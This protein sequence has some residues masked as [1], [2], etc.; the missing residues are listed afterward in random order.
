MQS[1]PYMLIVD[2]HPLVARGVGE[3]LRALP[4]SIE[5]RFALNESE[6][7]RTMAEH[8]EPRLLLVD[9]WL[10]DGTALDFVAH[11]R[12]C[13]PGVCVAVMSGDDDPAVL[14]RSR[15]AGAHGFIP[16]H[17]S[18]DTFGQAVRALLE[19]RVW[20]SSPKPSTQAPSH[21]VLPVTPAE[22]G[23]SARQGEI[24]ALVL[25]GLP[26]K[27]IAQQLELSE[28]T[29]KE[30]VSAVLLRLGV[31]TRVDAIML[32]QGRRLALPPGAEVS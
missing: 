24:L 17:E 7:R 25:Q 16:K 32:L 26:N 20:F 6:A 19:Q 12:Q 22:L 3:F 14:E 29:V 15:S 10:A 23:L 27:R 21:R 18:V 5:C 30:H 4:L 1:L 11:V 8:G 9:F 2:D 31:R 13:H 28:S